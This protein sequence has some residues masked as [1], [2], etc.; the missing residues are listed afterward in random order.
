MIFTVDV[1]DW[2]QSVL[3]RNNSVTE[4]VLRSTH[5]VM[6]VL[7]ENGTT[8]TFFTLGNVAEKFPELIQR[9]VKEGHEVASHGYS[10]QNIYSMS[11]VQMQE[12][13]SKS[14]KI[15]EDAGGE[16][17]IGF[18]APNFSIREHLFHP[19]CEALQASG[20]RYDSSLFPMKVLKYGIEKKYDL[21]VFQ[22]YGI[23]E[24]YLSYIKLGKYK[25]PYFGGGYFRLSPYAMTNALIKPLPESAV[26]YMHPY[27]VDHEELSF[28]KEQYGKI[29]FKWRLTQFVGR[30][31]IQDK[32]SRLIKDQDMMSFRDAY[33][34]ANVSRSDRA[35]NLSSEVG[36]FS[37]L[38]A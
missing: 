1:E 33:Y 14:V 12:D 27:E 19:F 8:A 24:F 17:V 13:I 31:G 5:T 25:L 11:P 28:V 35:N 4:R 6:D 22:E 26:F 10:H 9:M 32:L 23:D 2:S 30:K 34:P 3:D 15:L 16:K 20:I 38:T 21:S 36:S 7:S 18:R 37:Q 29:P